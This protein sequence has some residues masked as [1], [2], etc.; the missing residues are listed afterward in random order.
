GA[1]E[2]V[3]VV[4]AGGP[5]D[6][7]ADIGPFLA[8]NGLAPLGANQ[9]TQVLLGGPSR[10]AD[11]NRQ[12]YFENVLDAE[13]VLAMAPGAS[14]VHVLAATSSPG[15]F[16]DGISYVVNHLTQAHAVSLSYSGCE[17]L[18][19]LEMPILN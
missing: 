5:P 6:A 17:R 12:L 8:H 19:T 9:Y 16:S 14:V 13:M 3:A 15:L 7:A 11:P 4:G 10:D 2:T 1:G 18:S